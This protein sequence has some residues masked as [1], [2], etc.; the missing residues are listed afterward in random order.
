MTSGPPITDE[1]RRRVA[2]LHAAGL[3][4]NAISREI[5]RSMATVTKIAQ[6]LGLS[7]DRAR[8][9]EATRVKQIDAKARRAELAA[10]LLEDAHRLRAQLWEPCT[11]Y[12]FG[13]KDNT[14]A[15]AQAPE[16]SPRDKR[17]IMAAVGL[18]SERHERLVTMDA[19]HGVQDGRDMLTGIAEALG[20]A[21]RREQE[22]PPAP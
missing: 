6:E 3:S 10:L 17:E 4:R 18:A 5:S 12:N 11:V 16:P 13:G 22:P 20:Q 7:F 21:W 14:F 9:A 15:A 1:D 8:T 2:E 19:D